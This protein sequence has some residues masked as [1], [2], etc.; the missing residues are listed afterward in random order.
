METD[1]WNGLDLLKAITIS[2]VLAVLRWR[3]LLLH[4]SL[5]VS[6]KFPVLRKCDSVPFL[7]FEWNIKLI[8]RYMTNER[9]LATQEYHC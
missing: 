7:T 3:Q 2:L 5:K 4:Q 6:T 8:H 1:D 9:P